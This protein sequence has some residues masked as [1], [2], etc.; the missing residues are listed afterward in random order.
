MTRPLLIT[1]LAVAIRGA[2]LFL[3][4]FT[5][6]NAIGGL[7]R[8]EFDQTVLWIDLRIVVPALRVPIEL[9]IG[10]GLLAFSFARR[11]SRAASLAI[12]GV[13]TAVAVTLLLNSVAYGRIVAGSLAAAPRCPLTHAMFA[14]VA[15][16]LAVHLS[17]PADV[18]S[19]SRSVFASAMLA[20]IAFPAAQFYSFGHT[21]YRRPADAIVVFGAHTY[22]D[23]TPSRPLRDRVAT[24]CELY[25]QGLAPIV[26]FSG[27]P[28]D[29]P[30]SEPEAMRRLAL[31]NGIPPT[32]I[33]VDSNGLSTRATVSNLPSVT[34]GIDVRRVLAVSN[35]Y[36]LLRIKLAFDRSGIP[37]R[38][39]P[40]RDH[41]PT[42]LGQIAREVAAFWTYYLT[43]A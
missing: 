28:G 6:L 35:F 40:A 5:V 24:A 11:P 36:H 32:A 33:L 15:A 13:L 16:M 43:T 3:G 23:G 18:G 10:T 41:Q 42:P 2:A 34:S 39:V 1:P 25:H 19:S 30:V 31:L 4:S 38:T 17:I 22:A 8:P 26:I 27:G 21:D 29:G 7:L 37:T 14:V 12:T 9:I 20:A